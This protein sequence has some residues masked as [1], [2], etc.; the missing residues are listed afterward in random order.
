MSCIHVV[1][2]KD[3]ESSVKT[4]IS[5][6]NYSTLCKRFLWLAGIVLLGI[7]C[8]SEFPES[9]PNQPNIIIIYADDVGYGDISAYGAEQIQTPHIDRLAEQG[10][11]FTNAYA[12]SAMCTPSRYSLLTGRYAF[13]LENAGILSAEDPLLIDPESSTLPDILGNA[14]YATSIVGKWHLGLGSPGEAIDWNGS[15]APGPL[16]VGF[17][18]SFIVPVTND[19]VPTVYIQGHRVYQLSQAD[20]SLEIVY[21]KEGHHDYQEEH[22]GEGKQTETNAPQPLV[23]NLP[24]GHTH[25]EKLRYPADAQHSGTIVNGIS[26]IGYMAGGSSAW[27]DDEQMSTV[28]VDKSRQFVEQHKDQPFFLY[29]S[30]TKNHVPRLPNRKF[31]GK[32]G[33]GLRGD[34]V[35]ELDW[36]VGQVTKM[37][38]ERNLY[39]NTLVIFTSD[40]GPVFYDGYEDGAL[41]DHNGHDPSG[42]FS[43][44]KY[45]AYEGGTRMPT[46]VSWPKKARKG[47]VSDAMISQVDML[48]SLAAVSGA[49]IPE[50]YQHDSQNLLPVLLGKQQQ[51]RKQLVQQS[52]DGLALRR[53]KWKYMPAA[54]RSDWAYNRHNKGDT[55]L[56]TEPLTNQ[57][58]LFN[59][60]DD[61]AETDN[62][63]EQE[64]K[65]ADSLHNELNDIINRYTVDPQ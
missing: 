60:Q 15:I 14:G 18:E 51:G 32:S 43:G 56:N 27:W 21:P 7:G 63:V 19:R 57:R 29:L 36:V 37:L 46:I 13:R 52:S 45:V 30:L 55:P 59:L 24:S 28:L 58:Y 53:G 20:D 62:L 41:T 31:R 3:R 22:F 54:E 23:G 9:A 47:V 6:F 16:E 4:T 49:Q 33:S 35:V 44:G 50:D 65:M 17:D 48:S 1:H 42:P 11:R 5:S 25:P 64:S 10:V 26:R 38:K 40:N 2:K 8:A 61:T 12:S 39:E 34:A